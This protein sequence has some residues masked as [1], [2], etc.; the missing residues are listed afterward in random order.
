MSKC[1]AP[2]VFFCVFLVSPEC[3]A[4][5]IDFTCFLSNWSSQLLGLSYWFS[6]FLSCLSS[7]KVLG[8]GYVFVLL[9]SQE[10][11]AW[12]L[13]LC[14]FC[15]TCQVRHAC[16]WLLILNVFLLPVKLRRVGFSYLFYPF[17]LFGL[18][19]ALQC[20]VL[21]LNFVFVCQLSGRVSN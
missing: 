19:V 11:L 12:S 9:A 21:V 4:L 2:V 6:V 8:F 16:L 5:V 20:M 15:D 17:F 7:Q 1:L 3:L 14:I 13:I 18:L 10:C